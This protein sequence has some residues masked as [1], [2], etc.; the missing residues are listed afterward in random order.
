[1]ILPFF[2]VL[3]PLEFPLELATSRIVA[4]ELGMFLFSFFFNC[5]DNVCWEFI[6]AI[7]I[8]CNISKDIFGVIN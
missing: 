4:I 2:D 1:M 8:D 6:E 3:P 5:S 7:E